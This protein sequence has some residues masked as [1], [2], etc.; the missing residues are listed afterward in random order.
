MK[1]ERIYRSWEEVITEINTEESIWY[2]A[3]VNGDEVRVF[4]NNAGEYRISD[5]EI[6]A[7]GWEEIIL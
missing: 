7:E 6:T 3:M 1:D 2:E 5:E 4:T